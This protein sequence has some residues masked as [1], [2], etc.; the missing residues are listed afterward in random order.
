MKA[1]GA[2]HL[3]EIEVNHAENINKEAFLDILRAAP[4]LRTI[5]SNDG[6]VDAQALYTDVGREYSG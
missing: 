6:H 3:R 1:S 2:L 5:K 4:G